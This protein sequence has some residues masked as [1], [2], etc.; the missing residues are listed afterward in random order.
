MPNDR[1]IVKNLRGLIHAADMAGP[2]TKKAVRGT[3]REVGDLVKVDAAARFVSTDTRKTSTPFARQASLHHTASGFRTVVRSRGVAVE[4]SIRRTTGR[5]PEFGALQM[6][7]ALLP[8]LDEEQGAVERAFERAIDRVA[9][10]F[11]RI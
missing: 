7:R 8:A 2:E 9:D 1:L 5:H 6:R 4:Q 10:H 11:D 3:F